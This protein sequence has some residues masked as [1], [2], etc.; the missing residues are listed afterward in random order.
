MKAV[1]SQRF[2]LRFEQLHISEFG[3]LQPRICVLYFFIITDGFQILIHYCKA[4]ISLSMVCT[5]QER[6]NQAQKIIPNEISASEGK[7][8]FSRQEFHSESI[9]DTDCSQEAM[10]AVASGHC[11]VNIPHMSQKRNLNSTGGATEPTTMAA[12]NASLPSSIMNRQSHASGNVND[13]LLMQSCIRD[14]E[15]Q[16]TPEQSEKSAEESSN[17]SG[18]GKRLDN[19]SIDCMCDSVT[20]GEKEKNSSLVSSVKSERSEFTPVE[21]YFTK[22]N[23]QLRFSSKGA[24]T[25]KIVKDVTNQCQAYSENDQLRRLNSSQNDPFIHPPVSPT[26]EDTRSS[27]RSNDGCSPPFDGGG[28]ARRFTSE[29]SDNSPRVDSDKSPQNS[30]DLLQAPAL[31]KELTHFEVRNSECT[32]KTAATTCTVLSGMLSSGMS[33]LQTSTSMLDDHVR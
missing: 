23:G 25:S 22:V 7:Y 24:V 9:E 6:L 27:S 3:H 14:K 11:T 13:S 19:N 10:A 31:F 29:N 26:V 33:S 15:S 4:L 30:T 28:S 8:S 12:L 21:S 16:G 20:L 32:T 2:H 18:S 1:H 17:G 5:F